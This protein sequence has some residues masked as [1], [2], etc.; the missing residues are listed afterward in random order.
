MDIG[1]HESERPRLVETILGSAGPDGETVMNNIEVITLVNLKVYTQARVSLYSQLES[2][3]Y[4]PAR[5]VV[6]PGNIR[7]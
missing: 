2:Y 7:A 3:S 4:I 1:W 5:G 6:R